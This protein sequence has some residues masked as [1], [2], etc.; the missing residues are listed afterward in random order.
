[1]LGRTVRCLS[2]RFRSNGEGTADQF[3][4][5]GCQENVETQRQVPED[6]L[7]ETRWLNRPC[8]KSMGDEVFRIDVA[9]TQV[10][11]TAP[12]TALRVAN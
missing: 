7:W 5:P 9:R 1:M 8:V 10:A 4:P 2:A 6:L 11:P 3:A 12:T